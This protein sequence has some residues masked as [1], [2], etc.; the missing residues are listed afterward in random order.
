MHGKGEG[1][2]LA[3][4]SHDTEALTRGP[5]VGEVYGRTKLPTDGDNHPANPVPKRVPNFLFNV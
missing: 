5:Y 2:A 3:N 1:V 4:P